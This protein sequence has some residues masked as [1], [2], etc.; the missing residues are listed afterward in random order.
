MGL[1]KLTPKKHMEIR[2][3]EEIKLTS[4]S[5]WMVEHFLGSLIIGQ[6]FLVLNTEVAVFI[7]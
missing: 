4:S 6:T 1:R 5:Q 3:D 7:V 2:C